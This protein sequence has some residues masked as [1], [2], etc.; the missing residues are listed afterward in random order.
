MKLNLVAAYRSNADAR[1]LFLSRLN[2]YRID[3]PQIANGTYDKQ[4]NDLLRTTAIPGYS[5]HHTGYTVDIG[6]NDQT[7]AV[8]KN[9]PCFEWLS[10]D[11]YKNAKLYGWIPSYPE[12]AGQQGPDPEPWEY[13]WVGTNSTYE[14]IK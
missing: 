5:R 12:G 6:C 9:T 10:A 3:I 8:F 4:I 14:A 11:N 13:V 2:E 7:L 1:N